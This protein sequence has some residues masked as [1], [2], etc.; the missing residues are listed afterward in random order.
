ME[1]E[2]R[3]VEFVNY[4]FYLEWSWL[5]IVTVTRSFVLNWLEFTWGRT[6]CSSNWKLQAW[7]QRSGSP[8]DESWG[9]RTLSIYH[10]DFH[11]IS[12]CNHGI[13]NLQLFTRLPS[14]EIFV[15]DSRED[16]G[17]LILQYFQPFLLFSILPLILLPEVSGVPNF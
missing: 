5:V 3:W 1:A 15:R 13:P 4:G 8:L 11:F 9:Q 7:F 2:C 16:L 6:F 14:P 17:V 10:L 12:C